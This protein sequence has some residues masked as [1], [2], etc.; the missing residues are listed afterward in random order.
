MSMDCPWIAT[1]I[2]GLFMD[3]LDILRV[4]IGYLWNIIHNQSKEIAGL[5]VDNV[6]TYVLSKIIETIIQ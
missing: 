4:G 6:N 1:E 5:S 2:Y 3:T